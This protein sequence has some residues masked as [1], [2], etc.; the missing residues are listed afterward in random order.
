MSTATP[1]TDVDT[2][3][4]QSMK[5]SPEQRLELGERIIDSVPM[6]RDKEEEEKLAAIVER[7]LREIEDG[8]VKTIPGDEAFRIVRED[9]KRMREERRA[10]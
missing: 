2:L 6:F 8:T 3:Y 4:E 1:T 5:L 10:T 9:L 7:R